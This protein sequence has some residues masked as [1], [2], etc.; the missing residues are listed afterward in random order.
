MFSIIL[1]ILG[2]H[3]LAL[4]SPWPSTIL[5]IKNSLWN[6]RKAG[7]ATAL[8]IGL[9]ESIHVLYSIL[10][11]G[12]II[13]QSILALNT[14]KYAWALYLLYLAYKLFQSK[15]AKVT[16]IKQEKSLSPKQGVVQGF[17]TGVLNPKATI[18]F[19]SLFSLVI[20]P[21][22]NINTLIIL[23]VCM[24]IN[25]T[26]RFSLVS[27]L[28]TRDSIQTWYYKASKYIDKIF[29]WMLAVFWVKLL[30]SKLNP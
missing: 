28:L 12:F 8:G 9:G 15:G 22:T 24:T 10:G 6:S 3:L 30:L 14:I 17:L 20:K 2:I 4:I 27:S 25:A 19:V 18:F 5:I 29:W 11:L 23:G 26:L 21:D 16:D 13:S 7:L 1:P